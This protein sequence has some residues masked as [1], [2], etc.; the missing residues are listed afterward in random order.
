MIIDF[1]EEL[2][3]RR[4]ISAAGLG[5]LYRMAAV[6]AKAARLSGH[7][8][9]ALPFASSVWTCRDADGREMWVRTAENLWT[10]VG[11]TWLLG[12]ALTGG[13][14]TA[15]YLGLISGAT[16][17]AYAVGDT[18]ASH[19]GWSEVASGNIVQ[20]VRQTITWGTP[21][22]GVVNNSASQISYQMAAALVGTVTLWGGFMTDN[23]T[24]GGTA[25]SLISEA[26]FDQGSATVAANNTITALVTVTILAG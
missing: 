8:H 19:P 21:S 9:E 26:T 11:A 3:R 18:A 17:P 22:G 2:Y 12:H 10:T 25:G 24:L 15:V 20:T 5:E 6:R 16:A 1:Y 14:A 4:A 23:N 7:G 13:S